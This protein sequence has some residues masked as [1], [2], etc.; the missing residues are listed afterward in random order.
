MSLTNLSTLVLSPPVA[1]SM[2]SSKLVQPVKRLHRPRKV[3][4]PKL[5]EKKNIHL[6]QKW[7]KHRIT[8]YWLVLKT[9]S[10]DS[11]RLN[12]KTGLSGE[13]INLLFNL[14]DLFDFFKI[15]VLVLLSIFFTW[16]Q[17]YVCKNLVHWQRE[18]RHQNQYL[19]SGM[20]KDLR[21]QS[22]L[23]GAHQH[24][25]KDIDKQKE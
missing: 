7:I 14:L 11:E 20:D 17:K 22:P 16:C 5:K 3:P 1:N 25:K 12:Q 23:F 19:L 6:K 24:L 4:P 10:N 8:F 2:A 21:N 9:V 15:L 18:P 13:Y